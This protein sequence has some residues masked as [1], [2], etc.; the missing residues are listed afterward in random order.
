MTLLL[1]S[2]V[3]SSWSLTFVLLGLE[4]VERR[5]R[6][7]FFTHPFVRRGGCFWGVLG[8][9]RYC[10]ALWV[11]GTPESLDGLKGI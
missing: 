1:Q 5:L 11:R 10:G 7:F 8:S 3:A 6:S 4:V 9:V 2:I